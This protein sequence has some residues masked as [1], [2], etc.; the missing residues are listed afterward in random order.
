M[1]QIDCLLPV[2]DLKLGQAVHAVAG[3]RADYQPLQSRWCSQAHDPVRLVDT[4]NQQLHIS[5]YYLADLD[6]LE[7][8]GDN[9]QVIKALLHQQTRLW[10][11]AGIVTMQDA[12]YWLHLGAY[13]LILASESLPSIQVI[14]DIVD[15]AGADRVVFSLDLRRGQVHCLPGVFVSNDPMAILAAVRTCGISQFIVLDTAVVGTSSG[16]TTLKLCQQVRAWDSTATIISGGGVRHWNDVD[17]LV[18]SGANR[19]LVSTWLHSPTS[20]FASSTIVP[21]R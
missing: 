1:P 19:V 12:R 17:A 18:Q 6:S 9:R 16:P 7:G 3:R 5:E 13:R 21:V 20:D 11:D 4:L 8:Q 15:F 10:L 2:L 14:K